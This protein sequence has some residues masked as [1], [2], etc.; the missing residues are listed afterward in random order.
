MPRQRPPHFYRQSAVVPFRRKPGGV[1]VLLITTRRSGRWIVPK[2]IVEPDLSAADS[3]AVEAYEEAG[4]RGSVSGGPLGTY[5]YRKWGGTCTVE[6]FALEVGEEC[7]DWPERSQR[8]RR[9]APLA[10]AAEATDEPALGDLIRRLG[11]RLDGRGDKSQ[12]SS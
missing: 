8:S 9:W 12:L 3:A 2:G 7:A 6:V 10:D 4:V 5:A 11:F 1:E